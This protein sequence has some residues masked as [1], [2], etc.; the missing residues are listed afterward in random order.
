MKIT[1]IPSATPDAPVPNVSV[2]RLQVSTNATPDGVTINQSLPAPD[3]GNNDTVEQ[4]QVVNEDTKPL[5]PQF[6]ALAKQRRA[7]QL[8][9]QELTAREEAFKKS[10]STE[11]KIDLAKLKSEPLRVLLENGVTYDQLTEAVLANQHGYNP[12]VQALKDELQSLRTG[13]EKTFADRD[14]Q[15]EQQVKAEMT[16]EADILVASGQDFE[17]VRETKSVPDVIALV[18]RVY[19]E[20]GRL[21]DVRE[22]LQL[23]E[24]ELLADSLKF[25][26]LEKVKAKLAP[27]APAAKPQQMRTLA[28]N[29]SASQ[30]MTA[31]QRAIAA[32]NGTLGHR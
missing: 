12:E 23:V 5:S 26:Q 30:P 29:D 28:S 14:S 18:E 2:R 24:D 19:K 31:K 25:A 8:K 7:L 22:A 27:P 16:R 13:V 6:A 1:P 21:L 20:Q 11:G 10:S 17:L 3:S 9:E 4:S 32:F 15:A